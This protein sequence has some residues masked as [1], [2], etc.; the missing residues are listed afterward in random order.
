MKLYFILNKDPSLWILYR[1]LLSDIP[2]N[3]NDDII[4]LSCKY[5]YDFINKIER[6]TNLDKIIINFNNDYKIEMNKSEL[7]NHNLEAQKIYSNCILLEEYENNA[8]N[9]ESKTDLDTTNNFKIT[10]PLYDLY[11]IKSDKPMCTLSEAILTITSIIITIVSYG[12]YLY[13]HPQVI[14]KD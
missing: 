7:I 1:G 5:E 12:F 6:F 8:K 11:Y 10:E 13:L 3:Y 4:E 14:T 2:E 9:K